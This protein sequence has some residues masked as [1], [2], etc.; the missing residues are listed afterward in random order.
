MIILSRETVATQFKHKVMQVICDRCDN[1]IEEGEKY[2]TVETS[3]Y[4]GEQTNLETNHYCQYCISEA[5]AT[6]V[7]K[8]NFLD[9]M[10]VECNK[11][12]ENGT[13]SVSKVEEEF[14]MLFTR[15]IKFEK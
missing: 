13:M 15:G 12:Y 4:D 3:I 2:Y 8:L 10:N 6:T 5:V 1:D 11:F 14:E 9:D 7:Q